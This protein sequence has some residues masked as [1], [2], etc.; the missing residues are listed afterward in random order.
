[1]VSICRKSLCLHACKKS[2]S[3]FISLL[4][5]WRKVTFYFGFF[6][7]A[8]PLT[9]KMRVPIWKN[10]NN[11][12]QAK[13]SFILHVCWLW[14]NFPGEKELCKF[15]NIAILYH[16]AKN[17]KKLTRH[18]WGKY[19]TYGWMDR[20]EKRHTENRNFLRPSIGRYSVIK[21]TLNF[22]ELISKHQKPANSFN[23]FVR[24]SQF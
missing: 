11:S 16:R 13:T 3:S 20:H 9:S 24:Y 21:V 1:M 8:W 22:P 18:S 5:Y 2:T 12:Q 6:G 7:H 19:W 17:Q 10:F 15:L 23:F 14:M 4:R